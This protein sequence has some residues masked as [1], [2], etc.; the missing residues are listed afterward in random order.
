MELFNIYNKNKNILLYFSLIFFIIS[1]NLISIYI[2]SLQEIK[3][4]FLFNVIL[5]VIFYFLLFG[6]YWHPIFIFLGTLT[7]FQGGL[8]ICSLFDHELDISYVSLMGANF[9]LNES[10]VKLTISL[11][12]LS[13]WFLLLGGVFGNKTKQPTYIEHINR[14]D[15]LKKI[16]LAIFF[17]TMPFFAYKQY[18]YFSYFLKYGYIAFYQSTEFLENVNFFVRI[19]SF[20]T[21]ISFLGYFFLEKRRKNILL[22]SIL[23]FMLSLPMLLSG[24]RGAFLTFWLTFFLFYKYRFNNKFSLKT[25]FIILLAISISSLYISYY[26]EGGNTAL[27]S[28]L[29]KNPILLFFEQQGV[30]FYVTAMAIEFYNDFAANILHYLM[31]EPVSAIFSTALS[32]PGRAFATDL[33]IKINYQGYLMGYGTGSSYLAEAYLLGGITGVCIIS[34]FIGF[35]LSK[36]FSYFSRANI[37]MKILIFTIIQYII[38]LPRDLLLMPLAQAIKVGVYLLLLSFLVS[39]INQI[40]IYSRENKYEKY[41][42]NFIVK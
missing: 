24:F 29:I 8:I 18:V 35:I 23:Y 10:T 33:M 2:I 4:F 7:L 28:I 27:E 40:I 1:L 34:F 36:T 16:F 32:L 13:Y 20:L 25:V 15:N 26:R 19:I 21:P 37:Y 9:Y 5:S 11:I 39:F 17:T 12:T 22:I 30:S 31:W 3:Y 38:Y 42:N 14:N 6:K 41:E